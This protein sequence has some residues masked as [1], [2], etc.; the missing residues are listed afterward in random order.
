MSSLA[1]ALVLDLVLW[2]IGRAVTPWA[3]GREA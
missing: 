2:L 1:L 3:R